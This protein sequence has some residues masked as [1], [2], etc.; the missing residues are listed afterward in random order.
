MNRIEPEKSSFL[1]IDH[2][3]VIVRDMDRAIEH[4][5]SL[6]IGPSMGNGHENR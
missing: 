3:G 4:Y 6:G 1:E 5:R 2:V